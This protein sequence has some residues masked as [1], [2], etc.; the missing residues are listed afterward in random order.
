VDARDGRVVAQARDSRTVE[1]NA[2]AGLAHGFTTSLPLKGLP[3]GRYVLRVEATPSVGEHLA[4]REVLFE[5]R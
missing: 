4:R 3:A 2:N 5:V 1:A